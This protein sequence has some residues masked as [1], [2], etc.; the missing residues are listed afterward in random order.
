MA[1]FTNISGA[2]LVLNNEFGLPVCFE[3]GETKAGLSNYLERYTSTYQTGENI[4]LQRVGALDAG[5]MDG[6]VPVAA[7]EEENLAVRPSQPNSATQG[8][9]WTQVGGVRTQAIPS[10]YVDADNSATRLRR[11]VFNSETDAIARQIDT[12]YLD[13]QPAIV[14]SKADSQT[15]VAAALDQGGGTERAFT[16]TDIPAE[17][18]G[19]R[20]SA[21]DVANEVYGSLLTEGTYYT[22][23]GIAVLT[24][25]ASGDT[26]RIGF[27]I[28]A[29]TVTTTSQA[30]ASWSGGVQRFT[31]TAAF[32][33]TTG[34]LTWT[35]VGGDAADTISSV[36][37]YNIGI[38]TAAQSD[39]AWNVGDNKRGW[40]FVTTDN[41]TNAGL[42]FLNEHGTLHIVNGGNPT[43][44]AWS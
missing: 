42:L 14:I 34:V 24:D 44:V 21:A 22:A 11:V 43:F 32:V 16:L 33:N 10:G 31:V 2:K 4:L 13:V 3:I 7:I 19:R 9:N 23:F 8:V 26:C 28:L 5:V 37:L 27:R 15:F 36:V 41:A 40:Y 39:A 18:N 25:P 35:R 12:R 30:A 17:Y 1:K 29:N 38:T 6:G 20:A